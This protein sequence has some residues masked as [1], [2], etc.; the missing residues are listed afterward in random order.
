MPSKTDVEIEKLLNGCV[1]RWQFAKLVEPHVCCVLGMAEGDF[2]AR[3]DSTKTDRLSLLLAGSYVLGSVSLAYILNPQFQC[4]KTLFLDKHSRFYNFR[5]NV[6]I[7][8]RVLHAVTEKEFL[9][10]PEFESNS[11]QDDIFHVC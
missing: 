11:H 9:D 7:N 10:S 6:L 4:F 5:A 3:Q 8:G 2:Y 1:F